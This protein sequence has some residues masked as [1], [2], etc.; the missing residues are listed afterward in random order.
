MKIKF[1]NFQIQTYVYLFYRSL[2]T[3]LWDVKKASFDHH[4]K[5][6]RTFCANRIWGSNQRACALKHFKT[7]EIPIYKWCL[8]WHNI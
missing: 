8:V 6:F 3:G 2:E 4:S 5:V 7:F 1:S